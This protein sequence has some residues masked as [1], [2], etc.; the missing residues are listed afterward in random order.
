MVSQ[1]G[2]RKANSAP[3]LP[4]APSP[5]ELSPPE[6][7]PAELLPP[8]GAPPLEFSPPTP[9]VPP[10]EETPPVLPV[11]PPE[12]SVSAFESGSLPLHPCRVPRQMA[13][14][15]TVERKTADTRTTR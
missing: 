1:A 14:K 11:V 10:L 3:L 9:D 15:K 12:L 4:P 6:P 13:E 7:C 8:V 2:L 5:P